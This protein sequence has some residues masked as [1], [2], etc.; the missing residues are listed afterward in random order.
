M[1]RDESRQSLSGEIGGE[2]RSK[3]YTGIQLCSV[4]T[5]EA[6]LPTDIFTIGTRKYRV[7]V[8]DIIRS[9]DKDVYS[10]SVIFEDDFT[11][12]I[13][14][15]RQSLKTAGV[16]LPSIAASVIATLKARVQTT[17]YAESN[18]YSGHNRYARNACFFC[19]ELRR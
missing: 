9:E 5:H 8:T 4:S 12:D 17:P 3:F 16:N 19:V 18:N 13:S 10:S 1:L 7:L 14:I 2:L 15:Y 11:H 6:V